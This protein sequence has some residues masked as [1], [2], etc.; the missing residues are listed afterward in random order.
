L[1][2]P[3]NLDDSITVEV[4]QPTVVSLSSFTGRV[5]TS[6]LARG[7]LIVGTGLLLALVIV[8]QRQRGG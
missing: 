4:N 2:G 3:C 1:D 7:T 5:N 6:P 8:W